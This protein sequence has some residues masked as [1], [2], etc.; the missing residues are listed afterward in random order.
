MRE[1]EG[2][3]AVITGAASGMGRAYAERFAAEGM[4]VVLA[5]IEEA[6]LKTAVRELRRQERD[7]IGV[8]CD[9]SKS[10]DV[11]DVANKALSAYGKIH[12]VCNNAGVEGYL[13]GPLWEATD[14][15]WQWTFG[16]NF[17]GVV[18]G[19]RTFLPIML[20]QDEE[21]WMVNTASTM[22]LVFG[23]NMYGITKHA[24]V[25]LTET[26]YGQLKQREAKVG[27]SVLCPGLVNTQIFY[28]FRNRPEE[29]RNE[30]E[31]LEFRGPDLTQAMPPS[32]VAETVLQAVR[33]EQFYILT[34]HDWDERMERRWQNIRT[35]TNPPLYGPNAPR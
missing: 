3:V 21:G 32:Q 30:D 5:D 33:D 24:V 23:G 2:K 13:R 16:V 17:L 8:V 14:K 20:A 18:N 4:K 10:E 25:A 11:E 28:G 22:G 7:V 9:V 27:V 1:F 12:L 15:D 6:A 35:R 29:L 34:D 19:M 31:K 26:L